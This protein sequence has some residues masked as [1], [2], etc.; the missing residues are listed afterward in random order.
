MPDDDL[1]NLL[2]KIVVLK[3]SKGENLTRA[4]YGVQFIIL[5]TLSI[6][7]RI[8]FIKQQRKDR[9][10]FEDEQTGTKAIS[11]VLGL[12][13]PEIHLH[14]Y[15]QRSLIKYLNTV[16]NNQNKEFKELVKELFDIDEFIGQIIVA[17]HSPNIILNDY[18]QIVRLYKKDGDTKIL[19]GS[20][21]TLNDQLQKHLY[22]QFPFIKEAFFARCAIFVEGDSEYASFPHFGKALS[23]EFDDLGICVIQARGEAIPQ[24]IQIANKFEIPSVGIT[25]KNNSNESPTL[26]NHYQ[27][28]LQDFEV[29]LISLIASGKECVLREIVT[30]FAPGGDQQEM[31]KGALNKYT[32]KKYGIASEEF[33]SNLKLADIPGTDLVKLKYYY[34]TW[35][36]VNKSFPLGKLIGEKLSADEIPVIYQTVIKKAQEIAKS[37]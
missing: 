36:S 24:L 5:V 29:E 27:T 19:S 9:G 22:L 34:L 2:S 11:L 7:E 1:E 13:E 16:I 6:L 17:T 25:D 14:P 4:G 10:I 28:T 12:D 35:F 23:I 21:L 30:H 8:Q 15:M 37:D 18:K 31:Q 3:D 33:T 20:K 26:P 32:F